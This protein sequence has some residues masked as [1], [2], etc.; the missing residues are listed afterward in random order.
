M[1]VLS[2]TGLL[3]VFYFSFWWWKFQNRTVLDVSSCIADL[4]SDFD[5]LSIM[6]Y[7]I[8]HQGGFFMIRSAMF[9]EVIG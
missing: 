9:D 5:W 1:Y 7:A 2:A 4:Y 6:S 3:F 8:V